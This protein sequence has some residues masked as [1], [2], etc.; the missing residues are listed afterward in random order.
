MDTHGDSGGPRKRRRISG[1]EKNSSKLTHYDGNMG[2]DEDCI[3]ETER[4]IIQGIIFG[5]LCHLGKKS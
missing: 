3:S 5:S 1:T 2:Y 4:Q